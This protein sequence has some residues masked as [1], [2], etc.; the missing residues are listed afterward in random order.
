MNKELL[1]A[2]KAVCEE[3]GISPEVIFEALEAALIAAYKKNFNAS[4]NVEVFIDKKKGNVQVM[5][6]KKV[7]DLVFEDSE[8]IDIE[9]ARK[10]DPNYEIGDIV[11]I[12]VTPKDF[13]RVSAA[14]AKQ[15]ITQRLKE[16]EKGAITEEYSDKAN[17][18]VSGKIERIEYGNVYVDLGKAE[19]VL[20]EKEQPSTEVGTYKVGQTIRCYVNGIRNGRHAAQLMLSR[21]HP[22]L[23][24]KLFELEVPEIED[25]IVEIKGVARE[26][27]SRTKIAVFSNDEN[28]DA[29]GACI[30]PRGGRV[31]NIGDEL[32]DEKIDIVKWSEDSAEFITAAL[33]PSKVLSIEINEEEKSAKVVVPEHQLSLAIGKSGQ[34]VRLAAKLTGWKI[35]ISAQ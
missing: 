31:Q 17:A 18:L 30:G 13:G 25:G 19:G 20:Y 29:Q 8:E 6:Q 2:L 21:T 32:G 28:V 5:A 23:V 34:N 16:A 24:K 33:S 14:T 11:N 9:D 15:V 1:N 27:G 4:Q 7:V 35:D 12:E 26:G 22:N 3:K 10:I